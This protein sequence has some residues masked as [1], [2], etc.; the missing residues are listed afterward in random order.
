MLLT[1]YYVSL[2]PEAEIPQT[3]DNHLEQ[4]I[5]NTAKT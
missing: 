2:Q 1:K 4:R 3:A 5:H